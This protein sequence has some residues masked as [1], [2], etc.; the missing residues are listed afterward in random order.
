M[1]YATVPKQ[2]KKKK[3]RGLFAQ[4][5]EGWRWILSAGKEKSKGKGKS[6]WEDAFGMQKKKKKSRSILD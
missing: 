3:D 6:I 5:R 1:A 4:S 2:K